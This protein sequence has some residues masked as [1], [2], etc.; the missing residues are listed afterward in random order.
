MDMHASFGPVD[1]LNPGCGY[2]VRITDEYG[3]EILFT[4]QAPDTGNALRSPADCM[5]VIAMYVDMT[6]SGD[7]C[8]GCGVDI[9]DGD[10]FCDPCAEKFDTACDAADAEP[11]W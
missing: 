11:S 7:T 4:S 8:Q 2:Q 9:D 1:T 5:R 10:S 6:V 3:R